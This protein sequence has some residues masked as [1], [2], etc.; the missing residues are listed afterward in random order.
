MLRLFAS[1]AGRALLTD[2]NRGARGSTTVASTFSRESFS[3]QKNRKA[4]LSGAPASAPATPPP[5][6]RKTSEELYK[7]AVEILGLTCSLTD[8]C[9]CLDCQ[10]LYTYW[11]KHVYQ[12]RIVAMHFSLQPITQFLFSSIHPQSCSISKITFFSSLFS[13]VSFKE[14]VARN[15]F[16]TQGAASY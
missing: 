12:R 13:A 14:S 8:S 10:V 1:P 2:S 16:I 7:E 6:T 5:R 3:R 4:L 15:G 11:I 9:R